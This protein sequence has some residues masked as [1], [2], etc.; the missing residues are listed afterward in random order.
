MKILALVTTLV[1][2]LLAV[3]MEAH[4]FDASALV[5][6]SISDLSGLSDEQLHAVAQEDGAQFYYAHPSIKEKGSAYSLEIGE[7]HAL[8]HHLHDLA[9]IQYQF[10]FSAAVE[11]LTID[12]K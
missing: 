2:G 7:A 5:K 1:A 9:E 4:S 6:D 8:Q 11:S 12:Q 3:S 10:A